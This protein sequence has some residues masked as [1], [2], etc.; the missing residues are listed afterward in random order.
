MGMTETL[1][2]FQIII[3]IIIIIKFHF[4]LLYHFSATPT[5]RSFN[6]VNN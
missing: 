2:Q 4:F 1:L 5:L 3:I 6:V